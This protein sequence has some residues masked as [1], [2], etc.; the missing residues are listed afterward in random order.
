[1]NEEG[2]ASPS[3]E[4]TTRTTPRDAL[5]SPKEQA[6]VDDFLYG[7]SSFDAIVKPVFVT[8][9]L[10]ALSSVYVSTP[11][12]RQEGEESLSKSYTVLQGSEDDTDGQKLGQSLVNGLVI[13]LVITVMTFVIVLLYKYRCMKL[14]IGYMI[15]AITSLLGF[16]SSEMFTIAIERYSLKIDR[17]SYA[18]TIY[19]FALVGTISLF[20]G[21][22]IPAYISQCYLIAISVIVAWQ[23]SHFDP[24]TAWV[25]LILLALYDLFAV[26]S[27]CGPLKA[28]VNL[29]SQSDAPHLPGLL[30]EA[31]LKVGQQQQQQQQTQ[32]QTQ[33]Q[34]LAPV[35]DHIAK[36]TSTRNESNTTTD[37]K[38]QYPTIP[39]QNMS[40]TRTHNFASTT[41]T[42]V[43]F[44]NEDV[45]EEKKSED[46]VEDGNVEHG[47]RFC[48]T[49]PLGLAIRCQVP[50]A[51]G[52][53]NTADAFNAEE[54]QQ[55][56]EVIFSENGPFITLHDRQSDGEP[57][58]YNVLDSD[59]NL[60]KVVF[61]DDHGRVMEDR[62][63]LRQTGSIPLAI[64]KL[65]KLRFVHGPQ[66]S[67]IRRAEHPT[68]DNIPGD[69]WTSEELQRDVEVFFP[70]GW[71]IVRHVEQ[72]ENEATR[73][74]VIKPDGSIKRIL[75]VSNEGKVFEDRRDK[76][77]KDDSD[78]KE[79]RGSIRL[80]LGDFIFYSIL[81]SKAAHYSFTTFAACV[82]AILIGLALTLGI[83]AY[84]GQALPA[85]P[86][87]IF[88]GVTFYFITRYSVQPWVEDVFIQA[89][90]V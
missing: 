31:N 35:S 18:I 26:L 48:G 39:I 4:A 13:V 71:Q 9:I 54:L 62:R 2:E 17:A 32:A 6:T 67:W 53:V 82:P 57:L 27:P 33:T 79:G 1:M 61:V 43:S 77:K 25:L 84:H 45:S 60:L 51:N 80:G 3:P 30:Y 36:S 23:L 75:F 50:L 49:I 90:Y 24:W 52:Q 72:R 88:L 29:M 65:N 83:L 76:N 15:V 68:D 38:V 63:H 46:V 8:M 22:G 34:Q 5:S 78:Q 56:I 14:L 89:L 87:S 7:I 64:A 10:A 81:V 85:L 28:L 74:A 55:P 19:N 59:N 70:K 44:S 37:D 40:N 41:M 86:I 73:Y 58:R 11:E 20:F 42:N 66:P 21:R 69:T 12:S 16:V 47:K